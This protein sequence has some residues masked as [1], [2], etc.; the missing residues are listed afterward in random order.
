[1]IYSTEG[2]GLLYQKVR[3][4]GGLELLK[5]RYDHGK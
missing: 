1:M 5:G 3:F 2:F 4:C